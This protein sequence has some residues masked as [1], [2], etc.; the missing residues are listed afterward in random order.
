MPSSSLSTSAISAS[1][2]GPEPSKSVVRDLLV[3]PSACSLL[4][5]VSAMHNYSSKVMTSSP[6][7]S[8]SSLSSPPAAVSGC[9]M[10][11]APQSPSVSWDR[12]P[13]RQRLDRRCM[14]TPASPSH[15]TTTTT[16]TTVRRSNRRRRRQRATSAWQSS[17]SD[18]SDSGGSGGVHVG[19][20]KRAHHNVLERRRRDHLKYSFEA[21]RAVVPGT[22]V[23]VRIPKVAILRRARDHV[24]QLTCASR[25]LC[26]EYAR[27]KSL[28][29]RWTQK[30]AVV[31][32]HDQLPQL[33]LCVDDDNLCTS[34]VQAAA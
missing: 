7:P 19:G 14:S 33:G 15:S 25:K 29:E 26:A 4:A 8:S 18:D 1:V 23:D 27:L 34:L 31:T 32:G 30:L 12:P 9:G 5:R 16:T 17:A 24:R 2:S 11:S 28:H 6:P 21:L 3:L 13:L 10:Y 22:A 20:G